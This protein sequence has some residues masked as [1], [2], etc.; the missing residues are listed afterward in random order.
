[1]A[2]ASSGIKPD[3]VLDCRG[4]LCPLPVIKTNKAIK[5]LAVG[6]VLEMLATDPGSKPDMLAWSRQT[7]HELLEVEEQDGVYRFLIRR[8]V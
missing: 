2:V 8:K 4:L 5:S 3:Q 1:M 7:G 6:Q